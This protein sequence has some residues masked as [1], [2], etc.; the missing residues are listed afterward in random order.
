MKIALCTLGCK[1]NYYES[2]AI[3][4]TLSVKG[5]EILPFE[6][7]ADIYIINTC[8]VTGEAERK[9][10]QMVRRAI[11]FGAKKVIVTGCSAQLHPEKY[12]KIS[13]FT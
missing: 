4:D 9:A 11:S 6:R 2:K 7:G 12:E 8:A 1:V 3:S 13:G 10:A 5:Y